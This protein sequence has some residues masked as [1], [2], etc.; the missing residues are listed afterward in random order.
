[1]RKIVY[2]IVLVAL[3]LSLTL[4]VAFAGEGA[5]DPFTPGE[6]PSNGQAHDHATWPKGLDG[7]DH[8]KAGAGWT[9]PTP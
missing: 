5:D 9:T 1:M 7:N 3:L 8:G 2:V 4:T 6:G